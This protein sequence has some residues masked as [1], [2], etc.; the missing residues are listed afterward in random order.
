MLAA[1]GAISPASAATATWV[2]YSDFYSGQ[3]LQVD[4]TYPFSG[5][6]Y[7]GSKAEWHWGSESNTWQ[8]HTMKRLVNNQ[9]LRKFPGSPNWREDAAGWGG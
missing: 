2:Y 6:C 4:G 9:G 7:S 5:A 3:C 8:G 1:T